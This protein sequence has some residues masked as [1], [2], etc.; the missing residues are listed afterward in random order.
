MAKLIP[1]GKFLFIFWLNLDLL[2]KNNFMT[3]FIPIGK[4]STF[5][6]TFYTFLN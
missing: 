6:K 1:I 4:T 5:W 3:K 2:G